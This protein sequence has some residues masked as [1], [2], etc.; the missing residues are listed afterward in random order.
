MELGCCAE[1]VS[2]NLS[3]DVQWLRSK[4]SDDFNSN[5]LAKNSPVGSSC[6]G[7]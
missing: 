6:A 3:C 5:N 4:P 7:E 1:K 2:S